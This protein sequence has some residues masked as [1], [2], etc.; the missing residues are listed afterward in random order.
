MDHLIDWLECFVLIIPCFIIGSIEVL[1]IIYTKAKSLYTYILEQCTKD[2][3]VKVY[4]IVVMIADA[5][6]A[7]VVIAAATAGN[8]L[9]FVPDTKNM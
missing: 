8:N 3:R 1:S 7:I 6:I 5:I 2:L 4:K 9:M